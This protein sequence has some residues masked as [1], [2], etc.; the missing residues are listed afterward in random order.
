MKEV[1]KKYSPGQY[2]SISK[3]CDRFGMKRDAYYK[4]Q[5]RYK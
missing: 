2:Q 1:L 3:L 5:R 4:Y